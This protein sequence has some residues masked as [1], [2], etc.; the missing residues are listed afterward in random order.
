M[1][2]KLAIQGSKKS[3]Q[4]KKMHQEVCENRKVANVHNDLDTLTGFALYRYNLSLHDEESFVPWGRPQVFFA[5][6]SPFNPIN[7]V[8]E[9]HAIRSGFTYVVDI[10]LEEDRLLPHPY[11]TNCTN[12]NV[13]LENI[14]ETKPRSQEMCKELCRSEFFQQ[15][16]GCDMGVSMSF[17]T[18]SFCHESKL[19]GQQIICMGVSLCLECRKT[20]FNCLYVYQRS[21]SIRS[22]E[23]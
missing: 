17:T 9:G 11:P 8:Y 14:N 20:A 7:P 10:K 3:M 16:I 23:E 22:T 1:P 18:D 13:K 6:H 4:Y 19:I 21:Q 12:Y 15:C 5:I 2:T